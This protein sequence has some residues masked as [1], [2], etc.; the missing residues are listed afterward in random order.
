MPIY[1]GCACALAK[2]DIES[3]EKVLYNIVTSTLLLSVMQKSRP[4]DGRIDQPNR[5]KGAKV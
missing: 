1:V 5:V 4:S 3:V 2:H